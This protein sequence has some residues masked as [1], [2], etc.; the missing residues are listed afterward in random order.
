MFINCVLQNNI[1]LSARASIECARVFE[2]EHMCE[3][4]YVYAR[5]KA[6]Y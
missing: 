4:V 1:K 5:L 2:H 6:I 3:G